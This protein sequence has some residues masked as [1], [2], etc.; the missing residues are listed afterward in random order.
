MSLLTIRRRV[1]DQ[2]LNMRAPANRKSI[3][4]KREEMSKESWIKNVLRIYPSKTRSE[5]EELHLKL[6]GK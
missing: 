5:A 2:S 6:F 1:N 4:E 3:N